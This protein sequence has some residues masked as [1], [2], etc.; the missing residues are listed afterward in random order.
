V[1]IFLDPTKG[2]YDFR[3]L[4]VFFGLAACLLPPLTAVMV[5]AAAANIRGEAF[6]LRSGRLAYYAGV[7]LAALLMSLS[8]LGAMAGL[9]PFLAVSDLPAGWLGLLAATAAINALLAVALFSLFS[10][11]C[12]RS[13]ELVL[14]FALVLMGLNDFWLEKIPP[15][16]QRYVSALVPP[17]SANVSRAMAQQI[18]ALLQSVAYLAVLLGLGGLRFWYRE[19]VRE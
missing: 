13:R 6:L 1:G 16:W 3:Y 8:W 18:P 4:A 5:S 7:L 9:I 11:L 10:A 17:L 15:D 19:F 14:P 2:P 12:G